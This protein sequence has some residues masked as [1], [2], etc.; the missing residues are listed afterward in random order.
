MTG[1]RSPSRPARITA[2][3]LA[4]VTVSSLLAAAPA[5]AVDVFPTPPGWHVG[6]G[7]PSSGGGGG[8]LDVRCV[9][10]GGS[11][12]YNNQLA[13]VAWPG[14]YQY[15][16][17]NRWVSY[18][19]AERN[20]CAHTYEVWRFYGT[21]QNPT[22]VRTTQRIALDPCQGTPALV[23]EE[24]PEDS[25]RSPYIGTN[26]PP[27]RYGRGGD[28][29]RWP[30]SVTA[31]FS[32][33]R[34]RSF[35]YTTWPAFRRDGSCHTLM[36]R[37]TEFSQYFY[38]GSKFDPNG[39]TYLAVMDA[40]NRAYSTWGRAWADGMLEVTGWG[41]RG[42]MAVGNNNRDCSSPMDFAVQSAKDTSGRVLPAMQQS[43]LRL[44]G[45]CAVPVWREH[46]RFTSPAQDWFEPIMPGVVPGQGSRE[47]YYT[48]F[49]QAPL[50]PVTL[51]FDPGSTSPRARAYPDV[52]NAMR[53]S[54]V[55]EVV[56]RRANWIVTPSKDNN[57]A[58]S[59]LPPQGVPGNDEELWSAFTAAQYAHCDFS[60]GNRFSDPTDVPDTSTQTELPGDAVRVV[61]DVPEAGQSGGA[62]RPTTEVRTRLATGPGGATILCGAEGTTT[63]C[64]TTADGPFLQD[65]Q[66]SMVVTPPTDGEY[67][68]RSDYDPDNSGRGALGLEF[69]RPT[70]GDEAYQVSVSGT[71]T[72]RGWVGSTSTRTICD[73]ALVGGACREV[74]TNTRR[75]VERPVRVEVVYDRG[76]L[77]PADRF[78]VVGATATPIDGRR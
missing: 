41:P 78:P 52:L 32:A 12:Y 56:S 28:D 36:G 69:Y 73:P 23:N 39:P 47:V 50:N 77:T 75:L 44:S 66:L 60:S 15:S 45:Y 4:V 16:W 64:P 22:Q 68:V 6:G 71:A 8:Q 11:A 18:S 21:V 58:G 63:Y 72:V 74:G 70:T 34:F 48:Y 65:L 53:W 30:T 55:D 51:K 67:E 13:Y 9:P 29:R 27:Y 40:W 1:M 42:E 5:A 59:W 61:V 19:W 3:L 37:D 20:W 46:R 33:D 31:L 76:G 62:N 25:A 7:G 35:A 57:G 24:H 49:P 17:N 26:A 10:G 2:A 54:V 38:Q 14:C 43:D